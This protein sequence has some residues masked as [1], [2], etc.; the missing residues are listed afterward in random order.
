[1][2]THYAELVLHFD[3]AGRAYV[4]RVQAVNEQG[5]SAWAVHTPAVTPPRAFSLSANYPNP[6][7]ASTE[8]RYALPEAKEWI[9]RCWG[10]C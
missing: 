7:N 2:H 1:M 10:G 3:L 4:V 8:I 6:F 9:S 5:V